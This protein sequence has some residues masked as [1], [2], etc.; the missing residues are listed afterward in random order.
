MESI[1]F[2][3][4][5]GSCDFLRICGLSKIPGQMSFVCYLLVLDVSPGL[6]TLWVL[7]PVLVRIP[8]WEWRG[9]VFSWLP[10]RFL[11]SL[12]TPEPLTLRT[13]MKARELSTW[14]QKLSKPT[15][16]HHQLDFHRIPPPP[17]FIFSHLGEDILL[18]NGLWEEELNSNQLFGKARTE[19]T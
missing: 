3:K 1:Y 16:I 10:V 2:P 4:Q 5:K 19:V 12:W 9:L 17:P 18:L 6:R 8:P 11:A 14:G 13:I 7:R 15:R